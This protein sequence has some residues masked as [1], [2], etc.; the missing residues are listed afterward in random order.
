MKIKSWMIFLVTTLLLPLCFAAPVKVGVLDRKQI[1]SYVTSERFGNMENRYGAKR[2]RHQIKRSERRIQRLKQKLRSNRHYMSFE[3]KKGL[4]QQIRLMEKSLKTKK[5]HFAKLRESFIAQNTR[6]KRQWK[7]ALN[8]V[9]K[10]HQVDLIL[11]RQG[12]YFAGTMVDLTQEVLDEVQ[13]VISQE[14][15]KQQ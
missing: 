9:A 4:R 2:M 10:K 11:E 12:V 15:P 1:K 6:L 13:K 8:K 14:A 7:V 5:A 3:E